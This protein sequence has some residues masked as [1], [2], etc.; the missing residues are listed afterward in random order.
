MIKDNN[1]MASFVDI[2]PNIN[3]KKE[4]ETKW[5]GIYINAKR[6]RWERWS[7][8]I[9]VALFYLLFLFRYCSTFVSMLKEEEGAS[10]AFVY[11]R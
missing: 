9:S 2:D 3:D 1:M 11:W 5:W 10:G 4:E 8:Y 6:G 7:I